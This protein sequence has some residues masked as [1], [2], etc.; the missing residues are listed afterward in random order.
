MSWQNSAMIWLNHLR[1][2]GF[3]F[4][5][6]LEDGKYVIDVDLICILMEEV[7]FVSFF[8]FKEWELVNLYYVG[9]FA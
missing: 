3:F 2:S 7:R 4:K 9:Y 5:I 1:N 6:G 8:V